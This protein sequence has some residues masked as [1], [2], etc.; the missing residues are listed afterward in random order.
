M[1]D[2]KGF[3]LWADGYDKSVQLS[4][5]SNTYPFAGYKQ[6]LNTIYHRI[7]ENG[8]K[9]ILDIGL[10][11]GT[12]TTELYKDGIAVTG[13]DFSPKMIQIAQEKMPNARFYEFDFTKGLPDELL[14]EKFDYVICTYAIHHIDRQ[15]KINL[16]SLL[17]G[18]LNANGEILIGDVIFQSQADMDSCI[19]SSGDEWDDEEVYIVVDE[20][21][22]D[23]DMDVQFI[24]GSYCSGVCII[25]RGAEAI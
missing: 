9:K 14:T 25:R 10:G 16:L 5:E 6:V 2:N 17:K 7:R 18:V 24:K 1:L 12:L 8:K 22:N 11:T 20:L 23:C 13:I 21:M 15:H 3:D 4:D 19:A